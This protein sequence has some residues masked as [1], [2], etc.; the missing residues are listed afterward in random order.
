MLSYRQLEQKFGPAAA[1]HYLMEIEKVARIASFERIA[2]DP[3]IRLAD[4][5]R[6][7]DQLFMAKAA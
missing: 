6:A 1:Y 7:Q 4:A 3:E 2:V 5:C